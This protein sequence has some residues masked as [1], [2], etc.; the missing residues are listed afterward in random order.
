[1]KRY[2]SVFM[3][4]MCMIA[5]GCVTPSTV[6][7]ASTKHT[8]NLAGLYQAVGDY[9][10]KLDAYYDRLIRQQR[11]GHIALHVDETVKTTA[12]KQAESI[13]IKLL[14]N[15]DSQEP[16]KDFILAG[17]ELS[18]EF[19]RWGDNFDAWVDK[20]KGETLKERRQ[21]LRDLAAKEEQASKVIERKGRELEAQNKSDEANIELQKAIERQKG[22][23]RIRDGAEMSDDK[24]TYVL[25]AIELKKQRDS[26]DA[27]LDLL[28]AQIKTMQAFHAKID[29]F[30]SIDATIDGGK[31][32]EAMTAGSAAGSTGNPRQ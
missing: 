29:E 13:S 14:Q 24:L 10:N 23:K 26:L 9:R 30:L 3:I 7:D 2:F 6:K 11:E 8:N 28:A 15:R 16:A 27:Q 19:V 18:N 17:A 31:I 4:L 25:V 5:S 32:A 12:E 21:S 22:A 20:L 1:M